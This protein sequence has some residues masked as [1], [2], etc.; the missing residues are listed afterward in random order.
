MILLQYDYERSVPN[1]GPD[2]SLSLPMERNSGSGA[3]L[4]LNSSWQSSTGG[5]GGHHPFEVWW[6]GVGGGPTDG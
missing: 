6:T 1:P 2:G 5:A 4:S 3:K